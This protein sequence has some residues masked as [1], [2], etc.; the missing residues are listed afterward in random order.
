MHPM[1]ASPPTMSLRSLLVVALV[2]CTSAPA[3][4][5]D[6][7]SVSVDTPWGPLTIDVTV[8]TWSVV[9]GKANGSGTQTVV[10]AGQSV[11]FNA[12]WTDVTFDAQ[13]YKLTEGKI[14]LTFAPITVSV[15]L[16]VKI[17]ELSL[18]I[19]P[20][21]V[22]I[23]A[24]EIA[25]PTADGGVGLTMSNPVS[26]LGSTIVISGAGLLYVSCTLQ[27]PISILGVNLAAGATLRVDLSDTLAAPDD[28][29]PDA[30]LPGGATGGPWRG[31][32][33][34]GAS[35][36][37]GE[38]AAPSTGVATLVF[39]NVGWPGAISGA[40]EFKGRV[41]ST[42]SAPLKGKMFG[43]EVSLTPVPN[44]QSSGILNFNSGATSGRVQGTF[45]GT[46]TLPN[47][48]AAV[49]V[50]GLSVMY[51]GNDDFQFIVDTAAVPSPG[52]G[53]TL[54][55]CSAH[56]LTIRIDASNTKNLVPMP[57]PNQAM[58]WEGVVIPNGELSLPVPGAGNTGALPLQVTDLVVPF[59]N[60]GSLPKIGGW[61]TLAGTGPF[62]VISVGDLKLEPLAGPATTGF[63]VAPLEPVAS[64]YDDK[65]YFHFVEGA[66]Q[67]GRLYGKL[68]IPGSTTQKEFVATATGGT[69]AGLAYL[70]CK[71]HDPIS[72]LG[73]NLPAGVTLKVDLSDTDVAPGGA[74][75]ETSLPGYVPN[76]NPPLGKA[77][78][79]LY[80]AGVPVTFGDADAPG[81]G[82]TTATIDY[83]SMGW[84]GALTD[85][86]A[87][88]GQVTATSTA[89]LEGTVFGVVVS[90]KPSSDP[91]SGILRFDSGS[92]SGAVQGTFDGTVT[93]P[94][95]GSAELSGFSVSYAGGEGFQ[96]IVNL[97]EVTS[98]TTGMG[99]GLGA[100]GAHAT[101]IGIDASNHANFT[102]NAPDPDPNWKGL[103]IYEGDL[104]FPVPQAHDGS[105]LALGV[106]N[107][108][109]SF[110]DPEHFD[111]WLLLKSGAPIP[112]ADILGLKI[113][114]TDTAW[115]GPQP[116][117]VVAVPLP[118][119]AP[120]TLL[121]HT[122][123]QFL[124]G[125]LQS[126]CVYGRLTIPGVH[127]PVPFGATVDAGGLT[128]EFGSFDIKFGEGAGEVT[129]TVDSA[130][131]DFD[132]AH[133]PAP[134][135]GDPG[136]MGLVISSAMVKLPPPFTGTIAATNLLWD[137]G[138]TGTLTGANLQGLGFGSMGKFNAQLTGFSMSFANGEVESIT[139]TGKMEAKPFLDQ[140]KFKTEYDSAAGFAF[141]ADFDG[142]PHVLGGTNGALELR[143]TALEIKIPNSGPASV[144]MD[145]SVQ[146][147]VAGAESQK[148][149]FENV[150]LFADGTINSGGAW[151]DLREHGHWEFQKFA[152][153]VRE[154]GFGSVPSTTVPGEHQIWVGLSGGLALSDM[155][156]MSLDIQANK[157]R[158]FASP[159]PGFAVE[160]VK[161]EAT[162]KETVN[163]KG[164]VKYLETP[165]KK[166]FRGQIDVKVSIASG[167]FGAGIQFVS[168]HILGTDGFN[169]WG[170]A[171]E[172][173]LPTCV[174]L[175]PTG[176][177]LYGVNGGVAKHLLPHGVDLYDWEPDADAKF[178]FQA[179]V[180]IGT[181]ADAGYTFHA[182]VTMTVLIDP[183]IIRVDG[184]GKLL[185]YMSD[186]SNHERVVKAS[187]VYDST[188]STFDA[189]LELGLSEQEP[190]L[191]P[192]II[193]VHGL[194][195]L[196]IGP[197]TAYLHVGTKSSPVTARVFPDPALGGGF[198]ASSWFMVDW[199]HASTPEFTASVGAYVGWSFTKKFK[200]CEVTGAIAA[201]GEMTLTIKPFT[202]DGRLSAS[203]GAQACGIGFN[204]S[205]NCHGWYPTVHLQADC[206][207]TIKLVV[208]TV[209][210]PVA[211][212]LP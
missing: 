158:W 177:G 98:P 95:G 19:Q 164:K 44:D 136:W 68:T 52:V 176:L 171:G 38:T 194:A 133:S 104:S 132:E 24:G 51:A 184:E 107:V 123:F 162:I 138:L 142:D 61:F 79:G 115:A 189:S 92:T 146:V 84:T 87:F 85:P 93:L 208:K 5:A 211:V 42:S 153:D 113:E 118:G 163:I 53:L 59:E 96:F 22:T 124:Q 103:A 182:N 154:I 122:Y 212:E 195:V 143:F 121:G 78:R 165:D 29:I 31:F 168:G 28:A 196:H 37:F 7:A 117:A 56:A 94:G 83:L 181:T 41:T 11:S 145:G 188:T 172:F 111:G 73:V 45:D 10:F 157:F 130:K 8:N 77:W 86:L 207:L 97:A 62:Q 2:V 20:Q 14:A 21:T 23:T 13:T 9:S 179:G 89:P 4:W 40:P 54:G 175:G 199:N 75:P 32:R 64:M 57:G 101:K 72:I 12:A 81:S 108:F 197:G 134:K 48:S 76:A 18:D 74:I 131:L 58:S 26:L 147:M 88:K 67:S 17:T 90:L 112:L 6:P 39:L 82:A 149:S 183:L 49:V 151:V 210:L 192:S 204:L 159:D 193:S 144:R 80:L 91:S 27:A 60:D 43:V 169:Y 126:G 100:W 71:V 110:D 15:G 187:L 129:V 205:A 150:R 105:V 1:Q 33:I 35:V 36:A 209:N 106:A 186:E 178:A 116:P 69:G 50:T 202:F 141:N 55:P 30:D 125:N 190:F 167:V 3:A 166:E 16:D 174:P 185:T 70:A 135:M 109:V 200:V 66:L 102:P 173:Q 99:L 170:V 155:W 191:V 180:T 46:V 137:H 198:T 161:V 128:A 120:A 160:E 156:G 201:G 203:I 63:T 47:S 140:V 114:V 65:T 139:A 34:E 25:A 152:V 148:I 127:D 119:G 206:T